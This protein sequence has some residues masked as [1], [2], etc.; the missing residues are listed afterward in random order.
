MTIFLSYSRKDEA[1]VQV[2]A[3]GF[4]AAHKE[5]WYDHD[6]TGG[7]SW[8]DTILNKIR[9]ASVF[10]FVLSEDSL[11]SKPCL[12]ELK[13]AK[14]LDR[15]VVPVRVG[16]IA[17][18]RATPLADRQ[19]IEFRPDNALS[20]FPIIAAVEEASQK[21]RPLPDPLPAPPAIPYEYLQRLSRQIESTE[22]TQSQQ[23]AVV[24]QLRRAITEETD[25]GVRPDIFDMLRNLMSKSWST[26]RTEGEV[27]FILRSN[28]IPEESPG[29]PPHMAQPERRSDSESSQVSTP[30]PKTDREPPQQ[31]TDKPPQIN[32]PQAHDEGQQDGPIPPDIPQP[33]GRPISEQHMAARRHRQDAEAPERAEAS[34]DEK[35]HAASVVEPGEG[36]QMTA[37]A[38]SAVRP[39]PAP[40][41]S[42]VSRPLSPS[43]AP[44]RPAE[45]SHPTERSAV[46]YA[47]QAVPQPVLSVRQPPEY[48]LLSMIAALFFF[49][50]GAIALY[51]SYQVGE[52]YLAGNLVG[53][54]KAS[55]LARAWGIAGIV[56]GSLIIIT[57][58]VL[59]RG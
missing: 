46:A 7:D 14:D 51:F 23:L 17:S 12:A 55:K 18:L 15:P 43:R 50:F 32:T 21:E 22:L 1:V 35:E 5:I 27:R 48:W 52:R 2:L 58:W 25:D 49:V 10:I 6:L 59:S 8:W 28:G 44:S 4:E 11:Q 57:I 37:V 20:S 33:E 30:K 16:P 36:S 13:Y 39:S 42:G 29:E 31:E 53:A 34:L 38:D 26:R 9:S 45:E 41:L 54:S 56:L 40:F 19:A 24:D 3:Q 47:T